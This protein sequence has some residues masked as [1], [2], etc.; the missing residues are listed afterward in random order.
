MH[1]VAFKQRNMNRGNPKR[2]KKLPP[3]M[4]GRT[5]TLKYDEVSCC[6]RLASATSN[7]NE[8]FNQFA[9][10]VCV[11]LSFVDNIDEDGLDLNVILHSSEE[12]FKS[13]SPFVLENFHS[14][15]FQKESEISLLYKIYGLT[16][17]TPYEPYSD[18][19]FEFTGDAAVLTNSFT[20]WYSMG[21][22]RKSI[23]KCSTHTWGIIE[24]DTKHYYVF[25][26][27]VEGTF[28][29]DSEQTSAVYKCDNFSN[30]VQFI[31]ECLNNKRKKSNVP[32]V[33]IGVGTLQ[34]LTTLELYV[35]S[36]EHYDK[37]RAAG[38]AATNKIRDL[39]QD[40]LALE[41]KEKRLRS[42]QYQSQIRTTEEGRKNMNARK[43]E[44]GER[45]KKDKF[46]AEWNEHM[47]NQYLKLN[48]VQKQISSAHINDRSK[49]RDLTREYLALR[50]EIRIDE[51]TA[52]NRQQQ[53]QFEIAKKNAIIDEKIEEYL[54]NKRN[55]MAS[56]R[57]NMTPADMENICNDNEN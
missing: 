7:G 54:R 31:L 51:E 11:F 34:P 49:L 19:T 45:Q 22:H 9:M 53:Q 32:C 12:I 26:P 18:L 41:V 6:A 1:S 42:Q 36:D 55:Y 4:T 8:N 15:E 14:I 39:S 46:D 16:N 2:K 47:Q 38:E 17:V 24:T 40:L 25:D 33:L 56:K 3:G 27:N 50:R 52:K 28:S 37:H 35:T 30:F 23:L 10:H 13:G 5:K 44:Y 29:S 21:F 57:N 48:R 20:K 43:K